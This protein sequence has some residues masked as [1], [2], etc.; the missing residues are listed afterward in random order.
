[1]A[2]HGEGEHRNG[3]PAH[4]KVSAAAE[5]AG[6]EQKTIYRAINR[7]D[8]HAYRPRGT[9]VILVAASD[10]DAWLMPVPARGQ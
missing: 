2:H 1:M 5:Y 6:V 4:Y 9:R 8:L 10:L 3:R 7:G